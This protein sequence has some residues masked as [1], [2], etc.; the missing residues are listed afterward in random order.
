MCKKIICEVCGNEF[1]SS[2]INEFDGE[3]LCDDCY[4]ELTVNCSICGKTM[5]RESAMEH[6]DRFFCNTCFNN[7]YRYCTECDEV[8]PLSEIY[9]YE[10]EPYCRSCYNKIDYYI[11]DYNYKPEPIFFG[12]GNKY[13]G[14]ELEIDEG[15]ESEYNAQL[16]Q[17]IANNKDSHIYIK[18]DSSLDEG[19]EIVTHPMTLDYH[20]N[21][22]PWKEVLEK[23]KDL[24]YSS[25]YTETAGLHVHVNKNFFGSSIE[26]QDERISRVLFFVENNWDKIVCFSRRTEDNIRRWA[27][28]Y[29]IK[30]NPK[31]VLDKAKRNS[32][33]YTCVNITNISTIEF[34]VFRGTLKY[35]TLIATLQFVDE[36]CNVAF[37][38]SDKEIHNLT[39]NKFINRLNPYAVP[40]LITY[41]EERKLYTRKVGV[42]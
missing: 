11:K 31:D 38:M 25:H 21:N 32:S 34:R 13:L 20:K 15:G 8:I 41:L 3:I 12:D 2:E 37:S 4:D 33:R 27:Y 17:D 1:D 36:I 16:I 26:E 39:W 22:M 35:N 28:K 19:M 7:N 42:K 5:L 29:D 40:E 24:D 14:V 6:N 10:D 9:Y 23:A 18:H 30:S